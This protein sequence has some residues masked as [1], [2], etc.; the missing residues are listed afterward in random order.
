MQM[1]LCHFQEKNKWNSADINWTDV[2]IYTDAFR[3]RIVTPESPATGFCLEAI[4][5]K[6]RKVFYIKR[7]RLNRIHR[8]HD[9]FGIVEALKPQFCDWQSEALT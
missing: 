4:N 2:P 3:G 9:T 1:F 8:S 6:N 5:R 7:Q